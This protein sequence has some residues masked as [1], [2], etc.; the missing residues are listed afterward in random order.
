MH[1][2]SY[3]HFVSVCVSLQQAQKELQTPPTPFTD[4]SKPFKVIEY[5]CFSASKSSQ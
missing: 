5:I 3:S 4:E 1:V 2:L